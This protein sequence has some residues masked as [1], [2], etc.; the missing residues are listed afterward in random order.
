MPLNGAYT[1]PSRMVYPPGRD[2]TPEP[3]PPPEHPGRKSTTP[4]TWEEQIPSRQAIDY[5]LG[6]IKNESQ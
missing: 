1:H 4:R 5:E 3:T 6:L 2:Y